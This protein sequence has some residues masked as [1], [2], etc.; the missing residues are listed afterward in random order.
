[1]ISTKTTGRGTPK[2]RRNQSEITEQSAVDS[3]NLCVLCDQTPNE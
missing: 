3:V 2:A 1:M